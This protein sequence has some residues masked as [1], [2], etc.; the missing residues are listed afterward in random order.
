MSEKQSRGY[1]DEINR[2]RSER[3]RFFSEH[4]ASP[5]GDEAMASFEGLEYFEIDE[6]LVFSA[7]VRP[8]TAPTVG[9]DSSTG[10]SSDYP[11]AGVI[12]VPFPEGNI[13]LLALQGEE[14]E[15][16][17]PF[18]DGTCGGDSYGAGRYVPIKIESDGSC[19]VDFNR[20]INPLCAYDPEFSC[21]LPPQ[22]NWLERSIAAGEKDFR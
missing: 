17:I 13:S 4:Y 11:V 1:R 5:L 6:S 12:D 16:F 19:V 3:D 10:F 20:A 7:V 22:E 2:W 18:R 15:A 21:P 9:I 14:E 8:R